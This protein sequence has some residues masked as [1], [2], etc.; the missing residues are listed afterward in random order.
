MGEARLLEIRVGHL[1]FHFQYSVMHESLTVITH[2]DI[3]LS[4]S[5]SSHLAI[6]LM[7]PSPVVHT[8]CSI[9][10]LS[11]NT[12]MPASFNPSPP[13]NL[14]TVIFLSLASG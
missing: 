3:F 14:K 1:G 4:F 8:R 6:I 7:K 2:K 5:I 12:L 10:T 9:A 11:S 13:V